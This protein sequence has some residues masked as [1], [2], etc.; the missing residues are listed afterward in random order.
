MITA[1]E[2]LDAL[3]ALGNSEKAAEMAKYHKV[4]RP[5]LGVSNPDITDLANQWRSDTD[6]DG[7]LALAQGLWDSNCHEARIAAA[8]LWVQARI[9]PDDD[10]VWDQICRWVPEFDGWA[11]A[12]AV[13]LSAHRRLAANPDR[14]NDLAAW[15]TSDHLWSK[16]AAL[17]FTLPWTKQRHPKPAEA[18]AREMIL[19]WAAEYTT[20]PNQFIQKSVSSWLQE[21]AKRDP[22]HVRAFLTEHG[23][24]MKPYARK[25]V[26]RTL[27]PEGV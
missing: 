18:A 4:D 1:P 25:D 20:D 14:L 8:K 3:T 21:L 27:P 22:D 2:A 9:K 26:A 19:G 13:A 23:A 12:D 15:T 16:R 10:L 7:R 5:Y 11:I 24:A 6:L 17:V